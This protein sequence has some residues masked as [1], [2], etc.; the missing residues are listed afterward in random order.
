MTEDRDLKA[1]VVMSGKLRYT[2]YDEMVKK[3]PAKNNSA[4]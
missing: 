2:I 3:G 4:A 1:K